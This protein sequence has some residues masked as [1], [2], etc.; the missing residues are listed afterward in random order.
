MFKR[1][2]EHEYLTF[3]IY[4]TWRNQITV[5]EATRRRDPGSTVMT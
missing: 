5:I 4:Q 1:I 2:M 3:W